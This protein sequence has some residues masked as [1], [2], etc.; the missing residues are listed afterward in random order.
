MNIYLDNDTDISKIDIK[1]KIIF[2]LV[3]LV[4]LINHIRFDNT[5][6]KNVDMEPFSEPVQQEIKNGKHLNMSERR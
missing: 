3:V 1:T 2:V 6:L 4:V 5:E